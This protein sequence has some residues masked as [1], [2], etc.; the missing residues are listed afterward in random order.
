MGDQGS[1]HLLG[2][3]R[4]APYINQLTTICGVDTG[5]TTITHPAIANNVGALAGDPHGLVHNACAP[6]TTTAPSLLTQV[7]SWRAFIEGMP[8]ACRKLAAPGAHYSRLSNPP[9]YFEIASC[10]HFDLPLGTPAKGPLATLLQRNALPAFTLIAP[11]SCHN[12]GFDKHC[13]GVTKRGKF[14]SAGD[15]RLRGWIA[16]L[17][18]TRS[19]QAGNTA[20][21][22][23]W[24]EGTPA[25]P[26][27]I[28]CTRAR[29]N[30]T[31][32]VPLLVISP[33]TAA[34]TRVTGHYTH[35]SLLGATERLLGAKVLLGHAGHASATKLLKAFGL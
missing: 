24:N 5:Y 23:T 9:T 10:P 20:I 27:H 34:A 12:T 17:T 3:V 18:R 21:F 1:K 8:N 4:V 6:C 28:D 35:Y 26:L 15:F 14:I 13:P 19:Y 25:K 29:H 7:P 16:A 31:C 30:A 11:D 32:N 22:V 2:K 33:Y